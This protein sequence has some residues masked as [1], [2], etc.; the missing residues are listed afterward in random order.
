MPF[1]QTNPDAYAIPDTYRERML[2]LCRV[3]E[4]IDDNAFDLRDWARNG[5]CNSVACAVGWA[6]RDDWFKGQ[7][8]TRHNRSPAYAGL[9][10]WK[11]VRAFFGLSREEAFHLFHVGKYDDASRV[12]VLNRIRTFA[13]A[14]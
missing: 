13:A 5:S 4:S 6:I 7:G 11:A 2:A 14:H 3:L 8:L 1:D 10:G 12:A 9:T